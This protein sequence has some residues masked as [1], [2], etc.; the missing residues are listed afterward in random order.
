MISKDVS[1]S[2]F[3]KLF[4]DIVKPVKRPTYSPKE[5]SS[6]PKDESDSSQCPQ[7]FDANP[8]NPVSASIGSTAIAKI[9]IWIFCLDSEV[10]VSSYLHLIYTYR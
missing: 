4:A 3:S 5:I 10:N 2:I 1:L 7:T 8:V 6:V 9:E